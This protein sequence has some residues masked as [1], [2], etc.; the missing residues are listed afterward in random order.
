MKTIQ[1]TIFCILSLGIILISCEKEVPEEIAQGSFIS[2]SANG[3]T[4]ST[5]IDKSQKQLEF[6]VDHDVDVTRLV[7]EF[8]IPAGYT[9]YIN[10]APQTSGVSVVNFSDPVTYEIKDSKNLSSEWQA[11]AVRLERKILVD[12]SHDGGVWWYPQSPLSG[13]DQD[14]WHQGQAFAEHLRA[15]GFTVDELGRGEELTEKMFFGYYI[16]IRANG[17]ERYTE[18]ELKVYSNLIKRGTNLV[19]FTD[20]KKYDQVD[21]LG[22]LIGLKFVGMAN[23]KI[24]RLVPHMITENISSIDYIAGSALINVDINPDIEVLGALGEED[25]VDLNFNGIKDDNEPSGLPVMGILHYP[26]SNIFFIGDLNGLQV[27][28]QPFIDNLISWMGVCF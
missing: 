23:G 10:G 7:P 1:K 13:F 26:K 19:F 2:F 11:K 28:P 8:D 24:S 21:E 14:K 15:K 27:M 6:E 17:F 16:I 18:K 12:A 9:V 20:H 5:A 25:Y 4:L 3:Q 22:D